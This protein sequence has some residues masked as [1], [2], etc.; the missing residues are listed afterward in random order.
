M[1]GSSFGARPMNAVAQ[2]RA[3]RLG[4]TG[5]RLARSHPRLKPAATAKLK[6][7]DFLH[8]ASSAC[9]GTRAHTLV[10]DGGGLVQSGRGRGAGL[11]RILG[12][13]RE[14]SP[15]IAPTLPCHARQLTSTRRA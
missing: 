11:P 4:W 14:G 13:L 6:G 12:R 5:G 10:P 3:S 15:R 2:S 8:V 9:L 7:S 1:N